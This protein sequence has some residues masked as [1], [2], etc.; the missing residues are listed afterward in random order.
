[1]AIGIERG[2]KIIGQ[3]ITHDETSYPPF[4]V[5]SEEDA[6]KI[7][8]LLDTSPDQIK[9]VDSYIPQINEPDPLIAATQ[10][11][12][13]AFERTGK[14]IIVQ[15]DS[16]KLVDK[17]AK[18]KYPPSSVDLW[19]ETPESRA[20]IVEELN[21]GKRDN[22]AVSETI[23][24]VYDGTK[25]QIRKGKTAGT[26]TDQLRGESE[27]SWEDMFE[28][29]DQEKLDSYKKK[30]RFVRGILDTFRSIGYIRRN[31]KTLAEM[32]PE[33]KKQISA[34][35]KAYDEL[36]KNPFK[37]GIWTYALTEA[38][39]ME[40]DAIDEEYFKGP[41][42]EKAR[43]HA[44]RLR[45]LGDME[46][47]ENL[48]VD[49]DK[50]PAYHEVKLHEDITQY[51]HDPNSNDLGLLIIGYDKRKLPNGK[52]TRLLLNP[53]DRPT[54]LQHGPK[55]LK[56]A[57]AARAYEFSIHH[58]EKRYAQIR[59]FLN[60]KTTTPR[61]N[62]RSPVLEKMLGMIRQQD[63]IL[64]EEE[65]VS[66]NVYAVPGFTNLAYGRQYSNE[67]LSRSGAA[68]NHIIN[69]NGIP[70]SIF[71]LGGM[72]PVTGSRDQVTTAAFSFM[73]SYISH[74]SLFVDFNR[75]LGLFNESKQVINE[76]LP[77]EE[78][79]D[80][81]DLVTRQIGVCVSGKHVDDI[82]NQ[83]SQLIDADCRSLRIYTTNPG[84]EVPQAAEAIC[85]LAHE[86][87]LHE[88]RLPFHLCVGPVV[89]KEQ[90]KILNETAKKYGVALTLLIGHGGGENCTSLE[91]GAAANAIQI[92]Y[93]LSL[94][95]EFNDVSLGFEGGLGTWFGPWMG[96][97]DQISKNGDIVRGT[98]ESQGGLH[99]L[100]KSGEPVQPY[101][102]TASPT[103]Q[104][105]ENTLFPDQANRTNPA[106]QLKNNEG[107]PNYMKASR[108]AE[109][110]AHQF[111]FYRS[112]LG[113]VLADQRSGSIDEM[114]ENIEK[115]GWNHLIASDAAVDTAKSHRRVA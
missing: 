60:G 13:L 23:L 37:L 95:K 45:V 81:K 47:N 110:M 32:T 43:K 3:I 35:Q 34:E 21:E 96:I 107:R 69:R 51:T 94:E 42:M 44:Y 85:K 26:I 2:T 59:E 83:A 75:R 1:M 86:R 58:N 61:T 30:N 62:E 76:T 74:N 48:E 64:S 63:E 77:E 9:I 112:I 103:T 88:E 72:P 97:I 7:A 33:E 101:S 104:M 78:N 87:K 71:S 15:Q 102:G 82:Q 31:F 66:G 53:D 25:S 57:L 52:E 18:T 22:R 10:R 79:A 98:V 114:M 29:N 111:A 20:S 11:A 113:R 16:L 46:P 39:Q 19:A 106:G 5:E 54:F 40:L 38:L 8:T 50:L 90:A 56:R 65:I 93:E 109:S 28:P 36:K 70:T 100:H 115:Y 6:D 24:A 27:H 105:I 84:V 49:P 41:E 108:W 99:V 80:I 17:T 91:G 12:Q 14:P 68:D 55:S 89:D 67:S 92:M 73:R 4:L